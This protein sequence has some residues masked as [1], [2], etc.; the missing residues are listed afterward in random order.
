M[1]D[2]RNWLA[3]ASVHGLDGLKFQRLSEHMSL[4]ELV[5]LPVSTQ[6]WFYPAPGRITGAAWSPPCR[7][8]ITVAGTVGRPPYCYVL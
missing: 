4:A 2:L 1:D 6:Y 5:S 3:L 7:L 8:S